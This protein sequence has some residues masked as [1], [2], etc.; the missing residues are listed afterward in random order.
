MMSEEKPYLS[1]REA[2]ALILEI[3]RRMYDKNFVASNDGNIS[4]KV[5]PDTLWTTPT[6]VSKGFMNPG[7]LVK[8]DL[9]GNIIKHTKTARN[10]FSLHGQ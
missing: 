2:Q 7:M 1:D 3:G 8:V 4:C 10:T 6:G 9:D 5:G